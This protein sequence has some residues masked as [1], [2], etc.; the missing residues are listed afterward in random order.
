MPY[1]RSDKTKVFCDGTKLIWSDTGFAFLT[2]FQDTDDFSEGV[3][4]LEIPDGLEIIC[5]N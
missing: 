3:C 2:S 1:S 4:F 5:A